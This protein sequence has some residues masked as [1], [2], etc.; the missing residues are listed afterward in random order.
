MQRSPGSPTTG[1][2]AAS[3]LATREK[4]TSATGS[5]S[6]SASRSRAALIALWWSAATVRGCM[7]RI[8]ATRS[9]DSTASTW[10]SARPNDGG[11]YL[12]ALDKKRAKESVPVL[13]SGV[14]WGSPAV[15]E[16]T[17][18]I[19]EDNGL[20]WALLEQLPDVDR[21]DDVAAAEVALAADRLPATPRSRSSS[22]RSTTPSFWAPPSRVPGPPVRARCWSSTAVP[23]MP[24][25]RSPRRPARGV[26]DSAPGRA[27]QMNAGAAVATGEILLF[28]HADTV[29][30][31]AAAESARAALATPGTVAG[32]FGF[33][34]PSAARWSRLISAV[35]NWRTRL[36]RRPY[37]DQGLFLSASLFRELGGFPELP[38]ME[39]LEMAIRLQ[40]LGR[41]AIVSEPAITSARAWERHGLVGTTLV[42]LTGIAAYRLGV[43]PERI[44]RWRRRASG[45]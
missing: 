37:G 22:P 42:N 40:R 17:L 12:V 11:Y 7:R 1:S 43:D 18:A 14:E 19:C 8:C 3:P 31:A 36:T 39:D 38:T 6:R 35:G 34:V 41:I 16:S 25:A 13:F 15:L 20:T 30:P 4:A 45:R 9:G 33:A 2:D 32:A 23:A 29:L 27:A 44:A 28:L 21:P 26:V 24:R 10:C 5:G